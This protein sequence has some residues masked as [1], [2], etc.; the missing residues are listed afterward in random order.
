ME[1]LP[2][3]YASLIFIASYVLIIWE[4]I[5]RTAVALL[6]AV[7]ILLSGILSQERAIAAIEFNTIGLLIGMMIIVGITRRTGVFEYIAIRAAKWAKAE[8]LRIMI[9]LSVITAI[10]SALLDNVTTVLLIVP[11]T[12]SI[13]NK[14]KMNPVPFLITEIIASNIGGTAT[15]I[16]DPPNIMIGG[17]TGLSFLAFLFNLGPIALLTFIVTIFILKA[18]YRKQLVVAPELKENLMSIDETK[19]I[20]DR[21]LLQKSLTVLALTMVGF[22]LHE[23]LHLE[24]AT[25]ALAGA[26][27]LLV[28][29]KQNPEHILETVEWSVIFFFVGLFILVGGLVEVGIIESIARAGLALTGG[30]LLPTGMLILWLSAIASSFVDNIPFVATMIPLIQEMGR[31]GNISDLTPL[32]WSLAL[33]GCL[34]GNGSLVG[35]AAN[36]IVAGMAERKGFP[37]SFMEFLKIGFPIMLFSIV[38]ASIYLIAFYLR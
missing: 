13:L 16:G 4:K 25:V 21:K 29:S 10:A 26:A 22:V 27:I 9:V 34:G 19:E 7:L 5:H 23:F 12:I 37:I 32:W 14:L 15:L 8:P 11:V 2:A 28:I 3:V 35:A 20:R 31:L 24:S 30:A 6:G 18:I 38:L 36:V 33:G 17:Y 1:A